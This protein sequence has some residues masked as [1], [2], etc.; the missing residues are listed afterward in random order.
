MVFEVLLV[1]AVKGVKVKVVILVTVLIIVIV[2]IHFNIG[3]SG[4]GGNSDDCSESD[5]GGTRG[6]DH[7]AR[8]P[9]RP[10]HEAGQ[11]DISPLPIPVQALQTQLLS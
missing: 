5:Y 7:P 2:V 9:D 1:I 10:G 6:S 11:E 4:N 3:M 8:L